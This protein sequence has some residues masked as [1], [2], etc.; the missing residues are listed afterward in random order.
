MSSSKQVEANRDN[1]KK[2][3]GPKTEEGRAASSKNAIK[4]GILSEETILPWEDAA[5]LSD[6]RNGLVAS[7]MPEGDL[8]SILADR[9]VS[10]TWRL[11]RAGRIETAILCWRKYK[12]L[13]DRALAQQQS[14]VEHQPAGIPELFQAKD[15]ITNKESY[16]DAGKDVTKNIQLMNSELPVLGRNFADSVNTFNVLHRYEAG[17]ERSLYKALHELQRIQAARQGR[18]VPLP[19][20]VDLH[21]DNQS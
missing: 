15:V 16:E 20:A 12:D 5:N 21:G 17:L 10:L 14:Y 19:I 8:E 1:S 13:F 18:N 9:V 3:T 2:S 6:L 4:H 7:L 11:R